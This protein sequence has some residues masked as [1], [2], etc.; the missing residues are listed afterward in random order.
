MVEEG[1]RHEL[2][3]LR[4]TPAWNEEWGDRNV[5]AGLTFQP[6]NEELMTHMMNVAVMEHVIPDLVNCVGGGDAE[7]IQLFS[8]EVAQIVGHRINSDGSTESVTITE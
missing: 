7:I 1:T 3:G 6:F 5:E 8:E 4:V 2:E